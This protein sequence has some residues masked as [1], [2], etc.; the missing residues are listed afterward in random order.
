M[1][2]KKTSKASLK[3]RKEQAEAAKQE[4]GAPVP[5]PPAIAPK[6]HLPVTTL[7]PEQLFVVHGFLSPS[8]AHRIKESL[9]SHGLKPTPP[10]PPCEAAEYAVRRMQRTSF[11][12]REY[13]DALWTRS[14]LPFILSS[15]E[16]GV[17]GELT[18]LN[19]NIRGYRYDA[20]DRFGR[21]YDGSYELPGEN[22]E[23]HNLICAKLLHPLRCH[24][25]VHSLNL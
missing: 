10:P 25:V 19:P 12:S 3:G 20:G 1:P 7:L 13:A 24:L 4:A 15:V 22:Q 23:N 18:G 17:D 6:P 21:H 8:E 5:G 2:S 11:E 16:M 9:E 14:G